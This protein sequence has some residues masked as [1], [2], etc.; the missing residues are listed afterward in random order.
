MATAQGLSNVGKESRVVVGLAAVLVVA[1]RLD[2]LGLDMLAVKHD[3]MGFGMIHPDDG[4]KSAHEML[5]FEC[6]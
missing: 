1:A 2:P 5:S 3:H 4:V 6:W